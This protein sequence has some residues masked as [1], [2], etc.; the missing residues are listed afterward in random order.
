MTKHLEELENKLFTVEET[1]EETREKTR[2]MTRVKTRE[3]IIAL[4]GESAYGIGTIE[5]STGKMSRR[6]RRSDWK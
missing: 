6:S 1:V 3:I 4:T 5:C 2:D